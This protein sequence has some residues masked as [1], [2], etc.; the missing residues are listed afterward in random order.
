[1]QFADEYDI[2]Y[3]QSL[4]LTPGLAQTKK[5][6]TRLSLKQW[7]LIRCVK[8][9]FWWEVGRYRGRKGEVHA[10]AGT[11]SMHEGHDV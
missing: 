6:Q 7:S 9:S 1:M 2:R 10:H 5:R 8:E 11:C 4:A 3:I